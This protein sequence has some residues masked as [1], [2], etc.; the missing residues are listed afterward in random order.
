MRSRYSA[1]YYR[2]VEYLVETTHPDTRDSRLKK[3]LEK[4]IHQA[5]WSRLTIINS[6]RGTKEDK[7]GKVEF[8][9]KYFLDG[10]P[11]ELHELSRFKKHKG[12]WKYLDGKGRNL[13]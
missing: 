6:S 1:Y 8:I 12:N 13:V 3:D 5:N 7:T 4:T 9:A 10:Q 11:H 2:R